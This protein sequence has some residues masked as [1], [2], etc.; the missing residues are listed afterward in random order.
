[1]SAITWLKVIFLDK[2][3]YILLDI[4]KL[5]QKLEKMWKK[6]L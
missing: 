1:M 2:N 6:N 5:D 4:L 3:V